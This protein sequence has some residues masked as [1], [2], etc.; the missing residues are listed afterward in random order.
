METPKEIKLPSGAVLY[1]HPAPFANSR[2]LYQAMLKEVKGMKLDPKEEV[3]VNFFK[4]L[5]CVGFS[6]KEIEACLW[7]CFERCLINKTRISEDY[8]EPVEK[9]DD[10]FMVCFE[11]AKENILPFT[12]SLYA[13]YDHIL[14]LLK[15]QKGPA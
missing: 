9:R 8:F 5:F 1:V 11:I 2:D 7:K 14:D 3:D 6:S 15:T 10:Y 4:D 13:K 12:K